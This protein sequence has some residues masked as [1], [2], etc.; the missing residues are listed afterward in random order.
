M[1]AMAQSNLQLSATRSRL[2]LPIFYAFLLPILFISLLAAVG[3][4][5]THISWATILKVVELKLLPHSWTGS[6]Q[7]TQADVVIVWLIRIPRVIVGFFVGASLAAAG[8]LLQSLFRNPLAEPTIVGVGEGAVL[9]GVIAFV[10]GWSA[11]ISIV[12]AFDGNAGRADCPVHRLCH[13]DPRRCHAGRDIASG[14][15]GRQLLD[16]RICQPFTFRQH[17]ELADRAGNYLLD[18]GWARCA[19]MDARLAVRSFR[20]AGN[21]CF[22]DS[23]ARSWICF[24]WA[25]RPLRL[26]VSRSSPP[27]VCWRSPRLSWLALPLLSL[28]SSASWDC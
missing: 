13:V 12:V 10:T 16:G 2:R 15:R 1:S 6:L 25:R 11:T 27:S 28:D 18:D 23:N 3:I 22:P 7:V 5:S 8:V 4:G 20:V 17:R 19:D 14:R 24:N 9:G 26:S 21:C